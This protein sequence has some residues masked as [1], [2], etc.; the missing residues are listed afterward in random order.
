MSAFEPDNDQGFLSVKKKKGTG[1]GE[2]SKARMNGSEMMGS[3]SSYAP[4]AATNDHAERI[5][6]SAV[7]C[8]CRCPPN[9]IRKMAL[10][11]LMIHSNP[12]PGPFS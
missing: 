2:S 6:L 8:R 3:M 4:G 5:V 9:A 10:N 1:S 11:P 12:G 7:D